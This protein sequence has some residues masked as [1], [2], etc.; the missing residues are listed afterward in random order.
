LLYG[1]LLVEGFEA[2]F[3]AGL[4]AHVD[5]IEAGV[6]HGGEDVGVDGVGAAVH[7]PDDAAGEAGAMELGDEG[8]G[9]ATPDGA[10]EGEV[11]VLEEKDFDA[12]IEIEGAHLFHDERGLAG[13][14]DFAGSGA[15]E[16][17]DGAEGAGARAAAAGEER[18]SFVADGG[19]GLVVAVRVGE[20]VEVVDESAH[21]GSGYAVRCPAGWPVLCAVGDAGDGAPVEAVADD[22]GEFEQG[23]LTFEADDA[24]E[25]GDHVEGLDVGEAGE[26]SAHGEV[27]AHAG[28]AQHADDA[29]V[30]QNVE[31]EDEREADDQ[32]IGLDGSADDLIQRSLDVTDD[33]GVTVLA[34]GGREIAEAEVA[35]VLEADEE[36]AARGVSGHRGFAGVED[37]ELR[38]AGHGEFLERAQVRRT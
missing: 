25:L 20:Q 17:L 34:Q 21:G 14:D 11:V 9:P 4:E 16:G 2:F 29:L 12:A 13:A 37:G 33:D 35:L 18:K 32:R 1:D 36:D 19:L 30:L 27:A 7:L 15:V 28:V 8:G 3:V 31:L 10:E 6:A 24:V 23:H 5:E 22:V 38:D 26:V